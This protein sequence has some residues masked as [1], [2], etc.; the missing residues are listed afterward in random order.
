MAKHTTD[1]E[2][3]E[4]A[5]QGSKTAFALLVQ[6][7]WDWVHRLIFSIVQDHHH[8]EDL[9]QEVFFQVYSR[10][11]NYKA[12]GKFV[13]W[14]KRIAVNRAKNFLRDHRRRPQLHLAPLAGELIA[15]TD[16][17][18]KWSPGSAWTSPP[19]IR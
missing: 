10:L 16:A 4:A 12:Q 17:D 11:V 1:D 13:A 8:A 15:S 9:T 18:R 5:I 7:H 2:F 3:I 6:H 19:T 14:L